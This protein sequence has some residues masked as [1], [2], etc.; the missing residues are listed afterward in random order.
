[1]GDLAVG[2]EV[3]A[4]MIAGSVA[5][6]GVGVGAAVRVAVACAMAGDSGWRVIAQ[7]TPASAISAIKPAV[8]RVQRGQGFGA[9]R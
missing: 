8:T 3:S 1:M 5:I 9:G 2:V 4:S 7:I 6:A